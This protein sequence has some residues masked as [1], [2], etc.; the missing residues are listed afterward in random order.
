MTR[1]CRV[2]AESSQ[3]RSPIVRPATRR[4]KIPHQ[5]SSSVGRQ[6][7]PAPS[8]HLPKGPGLGLAVDSPHFPGEE[9]TSGS[10]GPLPTEQVRTSGPALPHCPLR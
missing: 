2:P 10:T 1:V 5:D 6:V 9:S 4:W 7:P 3:G 8:P